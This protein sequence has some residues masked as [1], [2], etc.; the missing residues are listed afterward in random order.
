MERRMCVFEG[1]GVGGVASHWEFTSDCGD[2]FVGVGVG[3]CEG[4]YGWGVGVCAGMG[5]GGLAVAMAH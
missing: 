1:E 3:V 5:E 2:G 4:A